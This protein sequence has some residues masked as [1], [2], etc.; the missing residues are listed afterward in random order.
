MVKLSYNSLRTRM[1]IRLKAV[2]R[3]AIAT[4]MLS[5]LA[6]LPSYSIDYDK[7]IL[8]VQ[9]KYQK[10]DKIHG[11]AFIIGP[12]KNGRCVLLT[13]WHVLS[14]YKND[15]ISIYSPNGY[16]FTVYKPQ[17]TFNNKQAF[18]DPKLDLA[19]M[20][21]P[22]C[23]N[24]LNLPFAKA[25]SIV[26]STKVAVKGYPL[27]KQQVIFPTTVEGRITQYN[28]NDGYDLNYDAPTAKG[29]SG[30]PVINIDGSEILALHGYTDAVN[31]ERGEELR[32]GGRGISAPLVYRFL[33]DN[34]YKMP[35]SSKPTCLVGVC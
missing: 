34:G 9:S 31:E 15:P 26:V 5:T 24:S 32:V 10:L 14:E 33:R 2:Y 27:D 4:T 1:K 25:S 17:F 3:L 6:A 18:D 30:G 28:D 7:L 29:F 8:K 16:K 19:F 35:R 12:A 23:R 22:S 20:P 21:A 11:S 13:A